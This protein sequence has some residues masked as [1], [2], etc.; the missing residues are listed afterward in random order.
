[1]WIWLPKI[2]ITKLIC[3]QPLSQNQKLVIETCKWFDTYKDNRRDVVEGDGSKKKK[4]RSRNVVDTSLVDLCLKVD[5]T[6]NEAYKLK[7]RYTIFIDII[8][9]DVR[10]HLPK[11]DISEF[12]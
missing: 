12:V 7:I 5:D 2:K 9:D 6:R 10:K 4:N 1:M 8:T 3:N 11:D